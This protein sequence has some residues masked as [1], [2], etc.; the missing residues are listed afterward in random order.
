MRSGFVK[1]KTKSNNGEEVEIVAL[2]KVECLSC[3][4]KFFIDPEN[5]YTIIPDNAEP[6]EAFPVSC[7]YCDDGR[8][9]ML[10]PDEKEVNK[11][12]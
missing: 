7:V 12:G 11:E 2:Q 4:G 1:K 5:R 3:G 6:G 8:Y 9:V 10:V